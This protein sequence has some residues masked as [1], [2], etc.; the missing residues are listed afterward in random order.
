MALPVW[1]YW[2]WNIV[3]DL[4]T[5]VLGY[6]TTDESFSEYGPWGWWV[7]VEAAFEVLA[8]HHDPMEVAVWET[9]AKE[10]AWM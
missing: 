4:R 9:I 10:R 6:S 3:D 8:R 1:P 2:H 5:V 7:G